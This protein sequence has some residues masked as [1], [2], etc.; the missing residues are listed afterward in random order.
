SSDNVALR[1]I[2]QRPTR[3][4]AL[5]SLAL[6]KK[7]IENFPFDGD[8]SRSAA[9]AA[10]LTTAL[11]GI[12]RVVPI[13]AVVAPDPRTGKTFLVE[14]ICVIATGHRPVSTAGTG[15]LT[16]PNT[17]IHGAEPR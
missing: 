9:L 13:F 1:P 14:L 15:D 10:I 2:P 12:L 8:V 3:E 4:E 16:E 5:E 17:R 6:L 7:P 11:R